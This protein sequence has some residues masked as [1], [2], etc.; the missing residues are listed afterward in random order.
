MNP[1]T[2]RRLSIL[3]AGAVLASG[4]LGGF[5][6]YRKQRT[7]RF[8]A[9]LRQEGLAAYKAGD[10]RGALD[11][12]ASY[13]RRTPNDSEALYACARSPLV[14]IEEPKSRRNPAPAIGTP[15]PPSVDTQTPTATRRPRRA[16]PALPLKANSLHRNRRPSNITAD[17]I[18][19]PATPQ[20]TPRPSLPRPT[21]SSTSASTLRPSTAASPTT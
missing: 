21:R 9:N 12:L 13:I 8:Y 6:V 7:A 5:V 11:P 17:T 18:L 19:P 2:K 3:L 1:K 14:H 15:P 20:R 16:P 4:T 10:Y